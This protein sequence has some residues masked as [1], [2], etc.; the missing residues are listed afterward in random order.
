MP[1]I[2]KNWELKLI[3]LLSAVVLWFFVVGIENTVYVMPDS[4]VVKAQNLGKGVSLTAALPTVKIYVNAR[5]EDIKT[6]NK[7]DFEA[8]VD[9]SD[10]S[11]GDHEVPVQVSS[12]NP[13]V[14]VLKT[15]PAKINITLA[16][17]AEKEVALNPAIKGLPA[18]GYTV[19]DLK[20]D[21]AKIKLTAAKSILDKIDSVKAVLV[22]SG[23]ETSDINQNVVPELP[24]VPDLPKESINMDPE[25]I[26][27]TAS[28]VPLAAQRTITVAPVITGAADNAGIQ[29][30]ISVS[31]SA[32]AVQGE[33]KILQSL[34]EISTEPVD[35]NSLLNRTLPLSVTLKL[36]DGIELA[37]QTQQV[38]IKLNSDGYVQ[39][40]VFASV[41]ITRESSQFKVKKITPEQIKVTIAGPPEVLD[42]LK[43]DSVSVNLNLQQVEKAGK[44]AVNVDEIIVPVGTGVL[45]FEPAE[46]NIE[47][48]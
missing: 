11:S 38:T 47:K 32:V 6:V 1:G 8:Y 16:P 27:L 30:Y 14:S 2:L 15:D 35:I 3:S 18:D 33:D 41:V 9:L 23:T 44:V 46:I 19:K 4:I 7:N 13:Q 48:Y 25:Q 12:Q 28:I 34:K 39:K 10:L 37:D 24:A 26:I 5:G 17:V 21:H 36:P 22:L 43:S 31:P 40:S 42:N 20:T 45:S 29:K